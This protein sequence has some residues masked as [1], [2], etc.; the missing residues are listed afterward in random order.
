MKKKAF[1]VLLAFLG[2]AI[3]HFRRFIISR[4]LKLPPPQYDVAVERDIPVTMADGVRLYTDHYFPHAEGE[5][6]T[7]LIRTPYG[8]GQE[9]AFFGGYPLSEM[10]AQRFAERGYHVIL[11]GARGCLDSEGVFSP[12]V[13]EAADGKATVEWI[14]KQPWFNGVLGHVGTQLSGLHAVGCC[15][16]KTRLPQGDGTDHDQRGK[17]QCHASR[18]RVRFGDAP[19]LVA[20]YDHDE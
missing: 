18:W 8:R 6:P 5:Y 16:R 15:C 1:L 12:H 17:L 2:W 9:V 3:Y 7:V 4:A 13:N 11:Q 10:P 14:A 19:A 20:G